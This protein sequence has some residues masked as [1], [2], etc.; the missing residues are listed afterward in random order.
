MLIHGKMIKES[1]L[2]EVLTENK[3]SMIGLSAVVDVNNIKRA[4]YTLKITLYSL[5][6]QLCEALPNNL[7][8]L[9]PYDW[10]SQQSKDSASFL[11]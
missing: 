9:S 3:F 4:R 8:D 2:L 7:T 11:Y 1:G 6:N 5:L 10:L